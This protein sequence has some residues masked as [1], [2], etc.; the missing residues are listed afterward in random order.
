MVYTKKS[1]ALFIIGVIMLVIWYLGDSGALN[2]LYEHLGAG[3]EIENARDRI[4]GAEH[5]YR[6]G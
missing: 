6:D 3:K 2:G 1:P 5:M 4:E